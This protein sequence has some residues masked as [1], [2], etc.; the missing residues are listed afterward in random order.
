PIKA[1][2]K[3]KGKMRQAYFWPIYGEADEIAFSYSSS[4]AGRQ[5]REVLG[6]SFSET[7][8]SDGYEAYANYARHRPAMTHAQCWAHTRRHFEQAKDAEPEAAAEALDLIG[9]LYRHETVI[10]EKQLED[11]AKLNYRSKHSEPVVAAFWRWCEA[12]CRRH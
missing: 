6:E 12:Q 8:I 11:E 5:V 10:R 3:S 9:A 4:R 2:R 1:G 7:L